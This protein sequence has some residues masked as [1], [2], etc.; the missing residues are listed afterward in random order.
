[1]LLRTGSCRGKV[2]WFGEKENKQTQVQ[3]DAYRETERKR[4]YAVYSV[5]LCCYLGLW[6]MYCRG[7]NKIV[8]LMFGDVAAVCSTCSKGER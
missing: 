3:V 1:L 2:V 5:L 7:R 6:D 4:K 8:L